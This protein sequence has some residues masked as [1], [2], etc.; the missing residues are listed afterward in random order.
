MTVH[1]SQGSE[2]RRVGVVMAAYAKELLTRS[3][4]YTALTRSKEHCAIWAT[5]DALKKAFE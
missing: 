1:K 3:L 5:E 2:Y 4:L